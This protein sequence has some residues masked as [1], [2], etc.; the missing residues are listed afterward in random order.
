MTRFSKRDRTCQRP[1]APTCEATWEASAPAA[2]LYPLPEGL[3]PPEH[4][5]HH[6]FKFADL[7]GT[8]RSVFILRSLKAVCSGWRARQT[9]GNSKTHLHPVQCLCWLHTGYSQKAQ[10]H[11]SDRSEPIQQRAPREQEQAFPNQNGL[12]YDT[13]PNTDLHEIHVPKGPLCP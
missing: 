7:W 12:P 1:T 2:D 5:V 3:F 4:V 6:A 9:A 13:G 11:C 8:R 10:Q